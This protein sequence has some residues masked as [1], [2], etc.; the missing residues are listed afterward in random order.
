MYKIKKTTFG[1]IK[2]GTEFWFNKEYIDDDDCVKMKLNEKSA[3]APVG[4]I[5]VN[6]RKTVFIRVRVKE[7]K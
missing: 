1:K 2:V 4:Q 5:K 6:S 3:I 7:K